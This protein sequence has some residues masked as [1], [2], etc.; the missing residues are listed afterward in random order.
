[1]TGWRIGSPELLVVTA[2]TLFFSWVIVG[3]VQSRGKFRIVSMLVLCTVVAILSST[4]V[5]KM[6]TA[7]AHKRLMS[8]LITAG[9]TVRIS[10]RFPSSESD[11][12][13]M[14]RDGYAIPKLLEPLYEF[15]EG[16]EVRELEIPMD[17]VRDDLFHGVRFAEECHVTLIMRGKLRN[18]D[19]LA[20][21]VQITKPDYIYVR[22]EKLESKDCQI[23]TS[24]QRPLCIHF[25]SEFHTGQRITLTLQSLQRAILISPNIIIDGTMEIVNAGSKD[26]KIQ[27][28]GPI[29][30]GLRNS[31]RY[32]A[33]LFDALAGCNFPISVSM[34]GPSLAD[35]A[36][37]TLST[38]KSIDH[39]ALYQCNPSESQFLNLTKLPNL[40][41]LRLYEP[42]ISEACLQEFASIGTLEEVHL[43]NVSKIETIQCFIRDNPRLQRLG[44]LRSAFKGTRFH[45]TD[46][47]TI[48]DVK[49]A[50]QEYDIQYSTNEVTNESP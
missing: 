11:G 19:G 9:G 36:W 12:W 5:P 2:T 46:S 29:H 17:I 21:L 47:F 44:G 8:E 3:I 49:K 45:G 33:T 14:A 27:S 40:K 20:R 42:K 38:L 25:Q 37:Q 50:L 30:I 6:R 10:G 13:L 32:D 28:N 7:A 26:F 18:R 23:L 16:G 43:R 1:M 48:T 22:G 15:V 24:F 31:G 39:L 4:L 34:E 41:H 35:D